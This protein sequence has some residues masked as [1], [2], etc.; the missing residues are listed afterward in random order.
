M[1][2]YLD[3]I[4]NID[5]PALALLHGYGSNMHD[6]YSLKAYLPPVNIICLQAPKVLE[7]EAFA[8]YDINWDNGAKIIDSAEVASAAIEVQNAILSWIDSHKIRGKLLI[9]GFSQG[10]ILSLAI[11]KSAFKADGYVIMSGYMLPEWRD[12][13]LEIDIPVLQTHGTMDQVIPFDWAK[14]G[15]ELIRG[16]HFK[17]KSYP[18]AHNLNGDCIQDVSEFLEQF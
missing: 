9:G 11:L 18:M 2:H 3:H 17:F 10:A 13:Y 8:W 14:S 5:A 16:N 15:T 6:L 12:E 1:L 7:N 4:E